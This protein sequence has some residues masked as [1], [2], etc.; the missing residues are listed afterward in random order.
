MNPSFT[1]TIS[2][3]TKKFN[4]TDIWTIY[5][6]VYDENLEELVVKFKNNSQELCAAKYS[7][8][9]NYES[10]TIN[11]ALIEI[12]EARIGV[13]EPI[14]EE[15]FSIVEDM[16]Q[17]PGGDAAMMKWIRDK[18]ESIGYPKKEKDAGISGACY[19]SFVINKDGSLTDIKLLRGVSGGSGYDIIAIQ[20]IEAMPK[21]KAGKQNGREVAVQYNLP[22]KFT[23]R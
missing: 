11:N 5:Q 17:F 7:D 21:W 22:I 9:D 10:S 3:N 14:K 6:I 19:V 18:I 13:V 12:P 4:K 15:I 2:L 23:I 8:W 20:V 1:H 16:P